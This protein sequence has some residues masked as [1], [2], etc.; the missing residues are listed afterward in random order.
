MHYQPG[1]VGD[2]HPPRFL[3]HVALSER[4]TRHIRALDGAL[5]IPEQG[6]QPSGELRVAAPS[7]F[8]ATLLPGLVMQFSVR[9]PEVRFDI[10]LMDATIDLVAE[11]IDVAIRASNRSKDSSLV[12]RTNG[13][14]CT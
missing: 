6:E 7:D 1:F 2:T 8:G 5:G 12:A 9:Y 4:A 3:R 14:R 11:R 13:R 10:R